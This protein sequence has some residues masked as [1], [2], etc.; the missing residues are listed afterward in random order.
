ML[1]LLL[2][3]QDFY[4]GASI[5]LDREY[6]IWGNGVFCKFSDSSWF[7]MYNLFLELSNPI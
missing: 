7:I 2:L 4:V 6:V 3:E 5:S 1:P